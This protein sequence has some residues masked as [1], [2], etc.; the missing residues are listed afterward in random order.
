MLGWAASEENRIWQAV[1][2]LDAKLKAIEARL[3]D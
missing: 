3:R 1:K 2:S